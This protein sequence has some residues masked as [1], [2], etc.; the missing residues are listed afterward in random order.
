MRRLEVDIE[1]FAQVGESFFFGLALAGNVDFQALGDVPISFTPDGRG[2]GAL[3]ALRIAESAVIA[4][5]QTRRRDVAL[6]WDRP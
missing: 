2:E 4:W 1:G 3:H 5:I 6:E